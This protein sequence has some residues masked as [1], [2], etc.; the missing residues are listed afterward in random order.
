MTA[1]PPN[2]IL[3][4]L[5]TLDARRLQALFVQGADQA[6]QWVYA[7]AADGV[8]QA[9]VCYGRML[10]EGTGVP[11]DPVAALTW[12]RRAETQGD[13]DAVNMV[14]RCLDNGWGTVADPSAAAGHYARAAAAGHAWAQYN[15]GHLYLDGRGVQRDFAKACAHYRSAADQGHERAMNLLGRCTEEGWGTTR[16]LAA[17]ADWY[18]RSAEAGYFR[19]QYNWATMLLKAGRINEAVMWLERAAASGTA[20]VRKA[21]TDL[22]A[23][24]ATHA[25]EMGTFRCLTDHWEVS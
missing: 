7:I 4:L 23:A 18:R 5:A 8:A 1:M 13:I 15:L 10:L 25:G 21:V 22:L 20:G 16:D 9:Q 3:A 14:G 6:A 24:P 17:A 11:K 2:S 19:G 12:F